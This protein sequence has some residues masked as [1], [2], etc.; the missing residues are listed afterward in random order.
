MYEPD[1][2]K[3]L[4]FLSSN[5]VRALSTYREY[6]YNYAD[7]D[8]ELNYLLNATL[9]ED[10]DKHGVCWAFALT[11]ALT[12]LNRKPNNTI[13]QTELFNQQLDSFIKVIELASLTP[14]EI[15]EIY[16]VDFKGKTFITKG[17]SALNPSVFSLENLAML[18]P[19]LKKIF[20]IYFEVEPYYLVQKNK[21]TEMEENQPYL[22][23]LAT[24]SLD[25]SKPKDD[26]M[27]CGIRQG[28]ELVIFEHG[29]DAVFRIPLNN[30]ADNQ[31]LYKSRT[32][33]EYY[34][35]SRPLIRVIN[36]Q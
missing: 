20:G 30:F 1:P 8:Y 14:K 3:D 19:V 15:S 12:V 7:K 32:N 16:S 31:L 13:S 18:N 22:L 26:H 25:E 33:T 34:S 29:K 24:K 36:R 21:Y 17:S 27:V 5:F 10:W 4:D 9:G 28:D 11:D 2:S 23:I 6:I 35:T